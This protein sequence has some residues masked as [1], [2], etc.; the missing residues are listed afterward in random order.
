LEEIDELVYRYDK[1]GIM[2]Y[3]DE[4]NV[5]NDALMALM[6]ALIAYQ[7]R[8][9]LQ[10]RLRGFVKA[11]LFTLPQARI[12]YRAGFR[13]LLSGIESGDDG[14]LD[15]MRKHTTRKINA[16]WVKNCHAAG[17][18]AKALM[19]LGH[20]GESRQTVQNSL[21]WVLTSC[22]DDV[23]WTIITQYP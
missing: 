15:T 22:P 23:D 16:E 18:K 1:R 2:F 3:D 10:L 5:S 9:A 21:E 12:M 8:N 13:M 4:L 20:P 17:I 19:S 7:E 14:I 11:E 6:E